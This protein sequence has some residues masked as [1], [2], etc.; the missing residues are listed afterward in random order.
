[1]G[2]NDTFED[3]LTLNKDVRH[4]IMAFIRKDFW[5]IVVCLLVLMICL[6]S[7]YS[8]REYQYQCNEHWKKQVEERCPPVDY[9]NTFNQNFSLWGGYNETEN[10]NQDTER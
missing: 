7:L 2:E 10:T 5:I 3:S 9:Y 8:I 6:Y 1:M 4:K